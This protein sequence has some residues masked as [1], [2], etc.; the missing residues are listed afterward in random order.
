[1]ATISLKNVVK[2]YD[3]VT[4]VNGIDLEVNDGEF[5]VVVGP[6]GCG[7]STTLRMLAG[8]ETISDG[9][10]RFGGDVVNGVPPKDRNVAMVFQNYALYPHMTAERNMTF[11]MNS[12]GSYTSDE[13]ERAVADAADTLDI[14][15]LLDRKPG[16]L[17]GGERQRVAIGR[18]LVRDPE[19]LLM[20]EPLSN[21]DAKLRVEMRA[22]LAELHAELERTTIYV[23]HDQTEAMTLG[24]RVAVMNDGKIQQ[25]DD[26]QTLYDYPVNRFV[27][28][29]VGSPSMNVLPA[30]VSEGDGRRVAEGNG[31]RI[32]LPRAETRV[33][34]DIDRAQVGIRPED[35]AVSEGEGD[36]ELSVS[37]TEPLGESLLLRGTVGE[38]ELSVKADPRRSVGVGETVGLVA[39]PERLHLFRS[40]TGAAIYHSSPGASERTPVKRPSA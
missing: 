34:T 20:D 32:P 14:V 4:A 29:F 30:R 2:R 37:V 33:D 16:E 13:I 21:L 25:V 9:T 31:F 38:T 7:K 23:T 28:E 26:P 5:L 22:E 40:D 11:G 17:S 10:I 36:I 3:D 12:S 19:I 15:D 18:T 24:D 35:L 27:A 1:M 6:S 8:L 39:D